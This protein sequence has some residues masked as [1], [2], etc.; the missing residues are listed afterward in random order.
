MPSTRAKRRVAILGGGM[1]GLSAAWALSG[2][3]EREELEVCVYERAPYLGGKGASTRGVHG[4]IEEQ[5][6]L[7]VWLGYYDNAFRLMREVYAE[8]DRPATDP[9][10]PIATWRDAFAPADLVGVED[11]RDGAWSHWV[12]RFG[13]NGLE[14]GAAPDGP[15]ELGVATFVRRGLALLVDVSASLGRPAAAPVAVLSGSP[16]PPRGGDPLAQ[17]GELMR[18]AEIAAMVGAVESLRLLRS[19]IPQGSP[20]ASVV[21][22]SLERMR[23]DLAERVRRDTDAQRAAELA[24]LVITAI[25]GTIRD[26]LLSDPAG[27]GAVDHLDFRAWLAGHGARPATLDSP[28]VRG[29][30]DL[31]FAYED[32]DHGRP[33]FPAGLGMFLAGKLFF[34]YRGSI[35]WQLQ[36][37][38]GDV[39]FAPLHQALSARGVTFR[40]SHRVDALRLSRGGERVEA[41]ELTR[42]PGECEPLA[43]FGGLP[44]FPTPSGTTG[45]GERI[46]LRAGA[47]FD[48]LVLALPLGAVPAACGELVAASPRWRALVEGVPT[49]PTQSLQVW[50]RASERELGWPYP[51]STVSGYVTPFDTYAS[52]T[53]LLAREDWPADDRPRALAYFCSVLPRG[54]TDADV[55]AAADAFLQRDAGHLWPG[56]LDGGGRFRGDLVHARHWRANTDPADGYVQSP[57]GSDGLRLRA[58][59]SGCENLALAGDWID[60]GLNAGCI[61]AAVLGGIQAA[62]AVRGLGARDG[63][64][65]T[66]NALGAT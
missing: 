66:W 34:E 16:D 15:P 57:P 48:E 18:R 46:A 27:F 38:M 28:I 29:M 22:G 52:M 47:D 44:C 35:F 23:G 24:D 39:V 11:H 62:N 3:D 50:L 7:H 19:A 55:R 1:A 33:A 49:V 59:A 12:A 40:L 58:D 9:G 26:G 61:E 21:L 60:C 5:H 42:E 51:G 17:F 8:L 65:G 20:L 54:G 56:A 10:C 32:G 45:N 14:P 31:V 53:H 13:R 30:Y 63:V 37:G 4:R 6:G 36:A 64:L 41:V 2:P 25:Q 43:R